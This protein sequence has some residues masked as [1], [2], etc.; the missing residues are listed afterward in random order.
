MKDVSIAKRDI[1]HHNPPY[2]G[3][4]GKKSRWVKW[5]LWSKEGDES[6]KIGGRGGS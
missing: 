1:R 6:E 3:R 2:C 4:G 5:A